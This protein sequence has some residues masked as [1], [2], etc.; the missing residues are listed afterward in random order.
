[1]AL[2]TVQLQ[3]YIYE[4]TSGSYSGT[5]LRYTLQNSLIGTDTNVVFEIAELVRDYLDLTFNNDYLSKTIWVTTVAILLDENNIVFS[6][7]SPQTNTY[8]ATDGYGYF[9]DSANPELSRNLLITANSIYLPE[10]VAGKLP[11]FAE[12]VGLSLIHI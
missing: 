5:D 10:D 1:M 2:K 4:G 11:I 3:I 8:L 7:G 12:G 6:Y 9:E